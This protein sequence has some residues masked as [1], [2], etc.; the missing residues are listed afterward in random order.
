M[1]GFES[2]KPA[3]VEGLTTVASSSTETVVDKVQHG[4][5]DRSQYFKKWD[6]FA[7]EADAALMAEEEE[8]KRHIEES[9]SSVPRSEAQK[10][11]LE[12]RAAL[13]EAKKQWDGVQMNEEAM[14]VC[15]SDEVDV[16]R[17]DL[18]PT[19][20]LQKKRVVIF[21]NNTNCHY[22]LTDL[23]LTKV[24]I[25]KCTNCTFTLAC[26][27]NTST[28]EI[29]H[30]SGIKVYVS[31]HTVQTIQV[32]LSSQISLFYNQGLWEVTTKIYHSGVS[33][34]RIEYD[35]KGTG[36]ADDICY[37][38]LNDLEMA[39][40]N[41]HLRPSDQQFVTAYVNHD[42]VTDLVL[43]DAGGHI[44]TQREIDHRRQQVEEA[45]K[46]KGIDLS[47]PVVQKVLHEYDAVT[48]LQNGKKYKEEGNKVFKECDYAQ[49]SVHYTQAVDALTIH[50][51]ITLDEEDVKE[52]NDQLCATYSNRAACLL[53]LGD[54]ENA[55]IDTDACLAIDPNHTKAM[56]RKG[57][58]LHA[59][60]RYREACP[61][62][63]KALSLAPKDQS[64]KTAL[65]FAERKA[66][67]Q[68]R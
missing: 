57:L 64:I 66:Q 46:A 5:G 61:V 12:K 15:I 53:K 40:L 19:V 52:C 43:R 60:G 26:K 51:N 42:L 29:S 65:T 37:Q 27:I 41:P 45:A 32:D 7:N 62:L 30:C 24:F 25:E 18:C 9:L 34:L 21:R 54:H 33:D 49:A 35:H 1:S 2:E 16:G 10:K 55:L 6:A 67:T 13:R 58:A 8:V 38:E 47:D 56:F 50:K 68:G 63:G 3:E 14:K 28:V 23:S 36:A 39:Q 31:Q 20:D 4:V 44:T 48:E 22:H 11:D 17:R 59:L